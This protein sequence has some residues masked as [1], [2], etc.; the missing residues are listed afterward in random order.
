M[1]AMANKLRPKPF[2]LDDVISSGHRQRDSKRYVRS[3]MESDSD[4]EPG[5]MVLIDKAAPSVHHFNTSSL[6]ASQTYVGTFDLTPLGGAYQER[7]EGS[8]HSEHKEKSKAPTPIGLNEKSKL[9]FGKD[10]VANVKGAKVMPVDQV[11][12]LKELSEEER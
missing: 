12:K 10:H 9:N 3:C 2:D 6:H 4:E 11:Y 7:L 5:S 1:R 8:I